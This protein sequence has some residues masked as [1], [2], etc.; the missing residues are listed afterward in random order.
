MY[1]FSEILGHRYKKTHSR[2][3]A[4]VTILNVYNKTQNEPIGH[5]LVDVNLLC[6]NLE[7]AE[8]SDGLGRNIGNATRTRRMIRIEQY[9]HT[10]GR[11]LNF[12]LTQHPGQYV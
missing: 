12:L 5:E 7:G 6:H 8:G 10:S 3:S 4:L 11:M 1:K 9:D 2:K